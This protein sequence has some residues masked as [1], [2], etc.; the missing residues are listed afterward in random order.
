MTIY[1]V[2]ATAVFNYFPAY[3]LWTPPTLAPAHTPEVSLPCSAVGFAFT[4]DNNT[5]KAI[6]GHVLLR[7]KAVTVTQC[8][9][10]CLRQPRCRAFNLATV[11]DLEGKKDCELLEDD[12]KIINRQ[13]FSYWLFDRDSYKEVIKILKL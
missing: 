5:D 1:T 6:D 11:L 13:G 8:G 10:F 2:T 9:D 12:T 4:Q 7:H 3:G